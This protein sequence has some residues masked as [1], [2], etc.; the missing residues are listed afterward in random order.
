MA[1]GFSL[2]QAAQVWKTSLPWAA[3]AAPAA[4]GVSV[5]ASAT[6]IPGTITSCM[7]ERPRIFEVLAGDGVRRPQRERAHGA[8]RIIAV[9]LREHG[10]ALDEQIVCI[11]RLQIAIDDARFRV[12][13]HHGAAGIV[14]RLIRHD[15]ERLWPLVHIVMRR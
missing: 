14:R 10:R 4:V 1:S 2:W 11:P 13:A 7:D 9:L 8:G 12:G 15:G 5:K 6:A 3:S